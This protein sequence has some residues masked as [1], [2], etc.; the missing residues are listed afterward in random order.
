MHKDYLPTDLEGMRRHIAEEASEL[1]TE[2]LKIQRFGED[3]YNPNDQTKTTNIDRFHN[4]MHDL[5]LSIMRYTTK[6]SEDH[7]SDRN[8][9]E[10]IL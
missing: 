7:Y 3:N 1:I 8:K 2:Y 6:L 5:Q 10:N 4:E 9:G